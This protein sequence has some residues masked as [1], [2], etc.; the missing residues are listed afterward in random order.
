MPGFNRKGPEGKGSMTGQGMGLCNPANRELRQRFRQH[1]AT[2]SEN[3]SSTS[4]E[5][6]SLERGFGRGTIC[7]KHR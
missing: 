1:N 6:T 2:L 7:R 5:E 4:H 3:E